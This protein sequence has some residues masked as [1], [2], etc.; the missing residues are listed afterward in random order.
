MGG[1]VK[2]KSPPSSKK[3]EKIRRLYG[4][5]CYLCGEYV[6]RA[7][8]VHH[9]VHRAHGGRNY[10]WNLVYLCVDC[11]H[12]YHRNARWAEKT[13]EKSPDAAGDKKFWKKWVKTH[14][15]GNT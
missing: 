7:G 15:K 2:K 13:Q 3:L 4:Y 12:E 1:K 14:K 10:T 8:E 11:H 6:G 9:I 5:R